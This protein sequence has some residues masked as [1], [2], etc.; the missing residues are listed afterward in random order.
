MWNPLL[1]EADYDSL[2]FLETLPGYDSSTGV[3]DQLDIVK[4]IQ[5]SGNYYFMGYVFPSPDAINIPALGDVTGSMQL[6]PGTFVLAVNYYADYNAS[7]LGVMLNL[8]DKGSNSS[9][10]YG[11]YALDRIVASNMQ[12]QVGQGASNPPSDPGSNADN[13]FGSGYQLSPFLVTPPGVITWEV[14][15]LGTQRNIQAMLSCAVPIN[16]RS[17]GHMI[18][19]KGQG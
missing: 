6:I 9:L 12:L 1:L 15:N 13:P 17:V 14:V 11:D 8:W 2:N 7:P 3:I 16:N 4:E 18:V 10:F 19:D 5:A